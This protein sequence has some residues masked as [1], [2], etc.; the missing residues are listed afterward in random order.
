MQRHEV[1]LSPDALRDL[2]DID[3]YIHRHDGP[4]RAEQVMA[5][6]ESV[7]DNLSLTPARGP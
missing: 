4:V 6:I 2:E 3:D 1:L 7:I 5:R